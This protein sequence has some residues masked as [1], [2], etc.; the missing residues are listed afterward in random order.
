[1][2]P[3]KKKSLNTLLKIVKLQK[4]LLQ[5]KIG[6]KLR[7]ILAI[8]LMITIYLQIFQAGKKY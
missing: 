3:K 1:M 2:Y 8:T 5:S 6:K 4:F 7:G